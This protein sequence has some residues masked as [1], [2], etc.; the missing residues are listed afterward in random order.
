MNFFSEHA[1]IHDVYFGDDFDFN[2]EPNLNYPV[3]FI[4]HISNDV[5]DKFINRTY[6]ISLVDQINDNVNDIEDEIYS[7]MELI[8][9]DFITWLR[10]QPEWTYTKRLSLRRIVNDTGD[11]VA[12]FDFQITL[13]FAMP[14][15][16][17]AIPK[18]QPT[19]S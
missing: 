12:G 10:Y 11:R 5:N 4:E 13:S 2:A 1:Q 15:N 6:N 17:C 8:A 3:A 9:V 7:D 19:V 18:F 14:L 16:E